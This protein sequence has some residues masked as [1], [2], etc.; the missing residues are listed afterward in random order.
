MTKLDIRLLLCLHL[1][2]IYPEGGDPYAEAGCV[3]NHIHFFFSFFLFLFF[4]S[5]LL[6]GRFKSVWTNH[7]AA[8]S[9]HILKDALA[10]P[11]PDTCDTL[12]FSFL[13]LFASA[14]TNAQAATHFSIYR[15]P[16]P[17][18]LLKTQL[19]CTPPMRY[20]W[21]RVLPSFS[22]PLGRM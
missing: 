18:S 9:F 20:D 6:V 16:P 12:H 17:F 7:E 2:F 11:R 13:M 22:F 19:N 4:T 10:Y 21:H 15:F 8:S 14:H 5:L 1:R 3:R